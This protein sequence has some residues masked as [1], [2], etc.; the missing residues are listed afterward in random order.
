MI[1]KIF[2]KKTLSLPRYEALKFIPISGKIAFLNK[3]AFFDSVL[4]LD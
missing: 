4:K 2:L 1:A 3:K